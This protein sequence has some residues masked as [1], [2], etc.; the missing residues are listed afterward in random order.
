M[1]NMKE[2]HIRVGQKV[3]AELKSHGTR[4]IMTRDTDKLVALPDIPKIA[5][6]RHS[7]MFISF[8]FDSAPESNSASGYTTY[9]YHTKN[10]SKDLASAVNTAI[11]PEMPKICQIKGSLSVIT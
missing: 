7:D 1:I 9:Y 4:V 6:M 10:G 5:E 2:V 3:E 11:S 8:H